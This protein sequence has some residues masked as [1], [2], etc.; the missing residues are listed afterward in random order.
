MV[1]CEVWHD[2]QWGFVNFI[3]AMLLAEGLVERRV[4]DGEDARF[5]AMAGPQWW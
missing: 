1:C 3:M 2:D 4:D 5:R